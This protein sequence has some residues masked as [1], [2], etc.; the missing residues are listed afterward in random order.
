MRKDKACRPDA[1]G[2][3]R[4]GGWPGETRCTTRAAPPA[5]LGHEEPDAAPQRHPR[6]S[7][8]DDIAIDVQ[9][10]RGLPPGTNLQPARPESLH[11]PDPEM[12][13]SGKGHPQP[14]VQEPP[15]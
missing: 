8:A 14:E 4:S 10:D 3:A 6:G 1:S 15:A 7:C 12:T 11:S 9:L 13:G 2:P 5:R